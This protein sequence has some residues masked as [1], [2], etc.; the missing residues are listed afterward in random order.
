MLVIVR[1][2]DAGNSLGNLLLPPCQ[3]PNLVHCSRL[4]RLI[5][6]GLLIRCRAID[7]PDFLQ[8][9]LEIGPQVISSF[10]IVNGMA[11]KCLVHRG[12][13]FV[14][15]ARRCGGG[16]QRQVVGIEFI[17]GGNRG[18]AQAQPLEQFGS[19][20]SRSVVDRTGSR[21]VLLPR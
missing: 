13:L 20:R 19:C 6:N 2:S 9:R 5:G 14:L 10:R 16:R 1:M 12:R 15:P 3:F 8:L 11:G 18:V 17:A 7:A 21:A 4:R